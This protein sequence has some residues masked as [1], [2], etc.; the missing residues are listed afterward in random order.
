[1]LESLNTLALNLGIQSLHYLL[2]TFSAYTYLLSSTSTM[3]PLA[4]ILH[5]GDQTVDIS[6]SLRELISLAKDTPSLE[7]LLHECTQIVIE[8]HISLSAEEY[9]PWSSTTLTQL[10]DKL[11]VADEGRPALTTILLCIYQL[12]CYLM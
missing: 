3:A 2:F 6:S 11:K 9:Q 12:G 10:V 5:F 1:M 7:R 4:N 8:S